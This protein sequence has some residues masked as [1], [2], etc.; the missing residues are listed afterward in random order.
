MKKN[1]ISKISKPNLLSKLL[2][3]RQNTSIRQFN[4]A[5]ALFIVL[6][7]ITMASAENIIFREGN[8]EIGRNL[9]TTGNSTATY[10]M[11]DGSLLTGISASDTQWGLNENYIYNNSN[12]LDFNETRLNATI[13]ARDSDTT[14]SHL[15]NFTDNILWTAGFNATFD[16]RD[17][18]TTYSDLSEFNDNLGDRGY[19]H[20]SNFTDNILWTAGFNATFDSRDSDTTY[21]DLSEFSNSPG[22]FNLSDFNINN[23]YLQSNPFN[24]YNISTIPDFALNSKVDSLGNF[25]SWDKNYSDLIETPSFLSDFVDDLGYTPYTHLSNFTDNILWTAEFNNTFDS[26]DNSTGYDLSC[27]YGNFV[28]ALLNNGSVYCS[29]VDYNNLINEPTT[30]SFFTD[31]LGDRGYSHLSNFTD[32]ITAQNEA[33]KMFNSVYLIDPWAWNSALEDDFITASIDMEDNKVSSFH[34]FDCKNS[35]DLLTGEFQTYIDVMIVP[36][37]NITIFVNY[38]LQRFNYYNQVWTTLAYSNDLVMHNIT[39]T[40]TDHFFI[41]ITSPV[42]N[43]TDSSHYRLN[44]TTFKVINSGAVLSSEVSYYGTKHYY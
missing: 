41:N 35:T 31:N 3:N 5:I 17:S 44:I 19:T 40:Y 13:D 34:Y 11:G 18:D 39:G 6:L 38:S 15:S 30:L 20:L 21:S 2:K 14:Y 7:T 43:F 4:L 23:Y 1:L 16:I 37:G 24:F 42:L 10:F 32:D 25:S 12:N 22:Y 26:R 8:F 27:P 33:L 9:N 36:V 29:G 28:F